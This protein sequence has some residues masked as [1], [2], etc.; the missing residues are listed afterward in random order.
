MEDFLHLDEFL[1]TAQEEDLFVVVRAGP[2]ICAEF[3]FGGFPSYLLRDGTQLWVRTDNEYYM[4]YVT[5]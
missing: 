2:F 1:Q 3:E 5:R 4:N